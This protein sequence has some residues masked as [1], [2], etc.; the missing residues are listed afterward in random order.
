LECTE[1]KIIEAIAV[2][3]VLQAED[4]EAKA[5]V[6][7]I[8]AVQEVDKQIMITQN[9]KRESLQ[10]EREAANAVIVARAEAAAAVKDAKV[11]ARITE[12]KKQESIVALQKAADAK[13]ESD[14]LIEAELRLQTKKQAYNESVLNR[15]P[16]P[17]SRGVKSPSPPGRKPPP[18]PGRKPPPPPGRKPIV[19]VEV[20]EIL[21]EAKEDAE[22]KIDLLRE[23]TKEIEQTKADNIV[24]LNNAI[25][26]NKNVDPV[27]IK[28]A[29]K[30]QSELVKHSELEKMLVLQQAKYI[31][32]TTK[33]NKSIVEEQYMGIDSGVDI[34]RG[35]QL[36]LQNE[37]KQIQLQNELVVSRKN[38]MSSIQDMGL[39]LNKTSPAVKKSISDIVGSPVGSKTGILASIAGGVNNLK[40]VDRSSKKERCSVSKMLW[41]EALQTCSETC[42][43]GKFQRGKECLLNSEMTGM[44]EILS[45]RNY[46]E[47]EDDEDDDDGS[48]F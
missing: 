13:A 44:E 5:K 42:A 45:R 17:P 46:I 31:N 11:K 9:N 48:W 29:V 6:D 7:A 43:D 39:K 18:P 37:A 14:R 8:A 19:P 3:G 24:L 21:V 25:I 12:V 20:D 33:L 10:R 16:S 41:D 40:P 47:S 30:M 34:E 38:V 2:K 15:R 28:T 22:M 32:G 4:N 36:R 23:Q 26:K 1:S 27:V 35:E